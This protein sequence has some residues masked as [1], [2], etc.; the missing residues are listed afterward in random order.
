MGDNRVQSRM[1]FKLWTIAATVL[2]SGPHRPQLNCVTLYM[3]TVK[4]VKMWVQRYKVWTKKNWG[5]NCDIF[6]AITQI[7]K[8]LVLIKMLVLGLFNTTENLLV[9]I[10][11][12]HMAKTKLGNLSSNMTHLAR[13][14]L[15][16]NVEP[17]TWN[18][19]IGSS[20]SNLVAANVYCPKYLSPCFQIWQH[21]N[22]LGQG[23][24]EGHI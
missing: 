20:M 22:I 4:H 18:Q 17:S 6:E 1:K 15:F 13:G 14:V 9:Q 2:V 16:T 8:G 21:K 12:D 19:A 3:K 23:T 24:E 10:G 11:Q 5:Q 7:L